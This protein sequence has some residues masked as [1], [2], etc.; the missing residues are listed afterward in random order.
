MR[1]AFIRDHQGGSP[2]RCCAR[3]SG[4]RGA[5][6]TPGRGAAQPDGERR[7][8]IVQEIRGVHAQRGRPTARRGV[9]RAL[10]AQGVAC[11]E[12]T[13]AKLMKAEGIRSKARRRFVVRTTDSRH[14]RPV[15]ANILNREFHPTAAT[16][17]GPPTSP[18]CRP[19]GLALPGG[20]DRPV[21]PAGRRLGDRRPPA[22]RA[23]LRRLA[24][25]PEASPPQGRTAAPQRP[26]RAVRQRV[27]PGAAGRTQDQ[28]SMSRTGNCYDNAVTE[29]FFGT[30]KR[31]LVHHERT[32]P[33]SRP[34]V[35]VRVHRSVLQPPASP[36]D[37]RLPQP[38]RVRS[39]LRQLTPPEH[40]DPWGRSYWAPGTTH[41]GGRGGETIQSILRVQ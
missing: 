4:S 8:E 14:D 21:L 16:R 5:A 39:P 2:S 29:S 35:A 31:E 36:L 11:C 41:H 19:R 30:A 38:R 12:N 1:F 3:S 20:G 17:S 9:H 26:R 7:H 18:T 6:T 33:A 23:G 13:V 22:G 34:P 28:P 37:A 24:D 40:H 27:V 10:K 32:P 25:G 15:A